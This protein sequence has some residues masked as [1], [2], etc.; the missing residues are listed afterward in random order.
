MSYL[1]IFSTMNMRLLV[2]YE[3]STEPLSVLYYYLFDVVM[4]MFNPA[5]AIIA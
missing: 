4:E 3:L 5:S 1:E 2:E